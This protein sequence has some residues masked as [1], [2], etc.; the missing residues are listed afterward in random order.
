MGKPI[1][2][3][4]GFQDTLTG[5]LLIATPQLQDGLFDRSVIYMCAHNQ[6]GAMGFIVN[7]PIDRISLKDILDQL[8]MRQNV[9]DRELPVMFGGPVE[10]HR[11]FVIHNGEF[12]QDTALA[13][14]AGITVTANSAALTGWMEGEFTARA[15]LVLGYA[16]WVGGQ[17]ES[18]IES[19]SWVT[20]PATERLL[21]DTPP[22]ERWD[23][24]VASLGFD[25]GN[26]SATVGHA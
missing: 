19:G 26:F 24:A 4:N 14:S 8:Q 3:P 25:M 20:A 7:T 18:E 11:G 6:E 12:L 10:P 21:F 2:I 1:I 23:L 9:G 15:M 5:H 22:D 17:L 13:T 16:G